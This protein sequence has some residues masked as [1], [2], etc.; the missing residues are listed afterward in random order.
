MSSVR[1]VGDTSRPDYPDSLVVH[2][3]ILALD[4]R[5]VWPD[6]SLELI[7]VD[8]VDNVFLCVYPP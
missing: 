8:V 7:P 4:E 5:S 6:L 2:G 3:G 1:G